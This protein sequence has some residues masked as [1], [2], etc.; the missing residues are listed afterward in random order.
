MLALGWVGRTIDK[1]EMRFGETLAKIGP[2][3]EIE[4]FD[5]SKSVPTTFERN[6]RCL[7]SGA[8]CDGVSG[9]FRLI[10]PLRGMFNAGGRRQRA[11]QQ[12]SRAPGAEFE[13]GRAARQNGRKFFEEMATCLR[14][15]P[16]RYRHVCLVAIFALVPGDQLVKLRFERND[17]IG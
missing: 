5:Q 3:C 17:F 12:V 8:F 9:I 13:G 7:V 4:R 16:C 10:E 6:D 2:F 1:D 14:K 15:Y 11:P